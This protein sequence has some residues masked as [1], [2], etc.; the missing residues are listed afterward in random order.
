MFSGLSIFLL[1]WTC[2]YCQDD[3]ITTNSSV[4]EFLKLFKY[5]R[6]IQLEAISG[7]LNLAKYETKYQMVSRMFEKIFELHDKSWSL[8][9]N[10]DYIPG[11]EDPLAEPPLPSDVRLLESLSTLL[12]NCA[13]VGDVV[14]RLPD[15]ANRLLRKNTQ[16]LGV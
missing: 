3:V 15:I 2:V 10:S 16:W 8:I 4:Q 5:K 6:S 1:F 7:L 11:G 13:L 14:L 12:E 9:E